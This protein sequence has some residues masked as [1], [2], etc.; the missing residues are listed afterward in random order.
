MRKDAQHQLKEVQDWAAHLE[1]L[2]SILLEFDANNTPG[3]S[4][5]SHT[6]YD[7]LRSLIKLWIADIGKDI[8]WDNLVR[9]TNK[10]EARA[11][12]Q[13]SI[14]LDQRCPKR[15]QPLKM[16]LNAWDDQTKKP[17][18]TVPPAKANPPKSDQSEASDK[19]RKDREKEMA[20]REARKE[21]SQHKRQPPGY[22]VQCRCQ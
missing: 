16:S 3:E 12:I 22:R 15:K 18:A 6:F 21:K 9:A 17:K 11:R 13:E 19:I 8:P 10:A 4:Q 5:L 7:G 2:Q 20:K 1:Y 14:Y